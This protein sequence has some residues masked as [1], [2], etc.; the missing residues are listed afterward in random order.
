MST[1]PVDFDSYLAR[2]LETYREE[3]ARD[4]EAVT[5]TE[6]AV[7]K[8]EL[9]LKEARQAHSTASGALSQSKKRVA[10]LSNQKWQ[11]ETNH[12]LNIGVGSLFTIF[13]IKA[14]ETNLLH[15]ASNFEDGHRWFTDVIHPE[16]AITF[17]FVEFTSVA[18]SKMHSTII[19]KAAHQQQAEEDAPANLPVVF[20]LVCSSPHTE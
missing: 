1:K 4:M 13:Q 2:V 9:E 7:A 5:E 17:P 3:A 19:V 20:I 12:V 8:A 6:A 18:T 15:M 10:S 14:K 16:S 11:A